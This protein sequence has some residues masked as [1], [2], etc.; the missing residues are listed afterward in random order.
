[1]AV[2]LN[3]AGPRDYKKR[4]KVKNLQKARERLRGKDQKAAVS[5]AER[6]INSERRGGENQ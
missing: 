6:Q 2:R 3:R 4:H 5:R 1:M